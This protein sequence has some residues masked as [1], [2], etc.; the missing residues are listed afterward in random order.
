[1]LTPNKKVVGGT[2]AV[3]AAVVAAV[4]AVEGGFTT[5]KNDRGNWTSGVVGQGELKGTNHGISAMSYPNLDIKNLTQEQAT[6][7]YVRDYIKQPKYDLIINLSP[8]VGQKLVD[9]GVNVGPARSSTW[10]QQSLNSLSRGGTDF[11]Q[12]NV[13]GKVGTN[14]ANTYAS[15]QKRRGK[16]LACELTIKLL[17]AQQGVHYMSLTK[18]SIYTPGW[19]SQRIGNVPLEKCKEEK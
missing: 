1:M 5:D 6:E 8:A 11:P 10:F 3:M 7:I 15:L 13:D 9:M 17:D 12:I 19:V 14:T 4:F 18:L 2:S 16:V